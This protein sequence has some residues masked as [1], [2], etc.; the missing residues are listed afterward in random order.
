MVVK[1]GLIKRGSGL[2]ERGM[3][4]LILHI[5]ARLGNMTVMINRSRTLLLLA[6][7]K[8]HVALFSHTFTWPKVDNG[9]VFSP[10]PKVFVKTLKLLCC[11]LCFSFGLT[12][13]RS[14]IPFFNFIVS[15]FGTFCDR[16]CCLSLLLQLW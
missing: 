8:A 10:T 1:E 16:S 15:L 6:L 5:I 2:V 7:L 9:C 3:V 12:C 13:S 11:A 4:L 14:T